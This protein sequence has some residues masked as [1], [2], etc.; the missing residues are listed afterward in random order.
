MIDA[1]QFHQLISGERRGP[2]AACLR[3]LLGIAAGGYRAGVA[4]RNWQFDS[5]RRG[6]ERV[7]VPV[8]S[9]GNL[10]LGGTGK[11]PMVAWLAR[12][13][14]RRQVR[15]TLISRG[16]GAGES[17]TN[18][19]ALEL[20]DLLP[21]VPH[22]QDPDRVAMARLAIEEFEAQLLVLDDGLQHRRLHRDLDLVLLDALEPWGYGR[23]FPRGLLREPPGALRRAHVVGL[24]RADLVSPQRRVELREQVARLAPQALWIELAHRPVGLR[25]AAD[26][27]AALD[28]CRGRK[29]AAF[30]GIG[31]PRGFAATLTQAGLDVVAL[32]EFPD[33][34]RYTRPDLDD[35]TA[36]AEGL[37]V[38]ALLTTH[39]DLVK[40]ELERLGARPLWALAIE[41]AVLAGG[42][43]LEALLLSLLPAGWPRTDV[44]LGPEP[45]S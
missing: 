44:S 27:R 3:G 15:V 11:T 25:N 34:H 28:A 7:G 4:W 35:L 31:N 41:L 9:V 42:E 37:P 33:H 10:T 22:L 38:D 18:D 21:D 32:R 8:V 26:D 39:K 20:E 14:R 16:Y 6:I 1:Q 12:W 36:W 24:S 13:F 29:V 23:L 30:C 40:I 19:E 2:A 17:G 43:Q 5:G 45:G